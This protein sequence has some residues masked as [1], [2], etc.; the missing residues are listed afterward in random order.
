MGLTSLFRWECLLSGFQCYRRSIHHK[1]HWSNQDLIVFL[2]LLYK[3][4]TWTNN[5]FLAQKLAKKI[6]N[7]R[8]VDSGV[9]NVA[10]LQVS[11]ESRCGWY[12]TVT[13]IPVC[14]RYIFL[15]DHKV[16]SRT[17]DRLQD[18]FYLGVR[19]K[20]RCVLFGWDYRKCICET[21]IYLTFSGKTSPIQICFRLNTQGTH[22]WGKDD[23]SIF[24]ASSPVVCIAQHWPEWDCCLS[25][26]G[27]CSIASV[28]PCGLL[29][30]S[31]GQSSISACSQQWME[32]CIKSNRGR[33]RGQTICLLECY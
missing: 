22:V 24:E 1:T 21:Q 15:E 3:K 13:D 28:M 4:I 14:V 7:E 25:S 19:E 26:T 6:H 29:M 9:R 17:L 5:C 11:E 30:A 20:N 10:L 27:A 18:K 12:A 33:I 2:H 23:G 31:L 16:C 32:I 8:A